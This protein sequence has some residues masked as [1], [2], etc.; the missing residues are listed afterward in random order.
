MALQV[1]SLH[2]RI[3]L[4]VL[5]PLLGASIPAGY[6]LWHAQ[7]D[8][9]EMRNLRALADLVWRLGDLEAR[10]DAEAEKW[11]FFKPSYEATNA[12]RQAERLNQEQQRRE[13]DKAIAAYNA[14]RAAIESASLSAP[15]QAALD[16]IA[17][18]ITHLPELRKM[19]Y[20]QVDETLSVPIMDG[21]RGFR[22]DIDQVLPLLVDA[23][24]NSAITRKLIV[25]PKL[26]LVRKTAMDA[27]GMIFY[28]HQL[29][30]SKS[31][32]TF[33]PSEALQM[34]QGADLAEL[35]WADV[36]A[37]SQGP[38]RNH[39]VALH[40]SPD[41]QR[42]V[43]M[44]RKHA[45]AALNHTEPPISGEAEFSPSWSF[46]YG[47]LAEEIKGVREDFTQS[48]QA[49]ERA[50]QLR[51]LWIILGIG[52]GVAV[53]LWLA[54]RLGH[55]ISKP[56]AG[57]TD[58]LLSDARAVT[59][60]AETVRTSCATVAD[61]SNRQAAALEETS[62]TLEEISSMTQSNADNAQRAQ[63]SANDTRS[64]AEQGAQQMR[65][66]TEAMEALRTSSED[67]TRIIK[68]IDEIAFQTNI[69]ALNAAV[70]AARAGEAGAGFAVVAEEVRSLAQRSAQAAR[71]TTAK[72]TAANARTN[73]GAEITVKVGESLDRILQ[74]AREVETLVDSIA[75]ASREQNSGVAQIT[76]A[77]RQI[78]KVTQTNAAAAEETA[79][80]A[81]E[82]QTRAHAFRDAVEEMQHIVFGGATAQAG[83]H[84][85]D[86]T[87]DLSQSVEATTEA[88][89]EQHEEVVGK[90]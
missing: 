44:L 23:T 22:R 34:S 71:E 89:E 2:R 8:L 59:S 11:Y 86:A 57:T 18:R 17:Q 64:A 29:R 54:N 62:A 81:A 67:V 90:Q 32:R 46:L 16:S 19:V 76:T 79:A 82:L 83:A 24:S 26:M 69:L 38:M 80:S 75:A 28:Y 13:T 66:L 61:G 33:V 73:A 36:I 55:S 39:L 60:E 3:L 77:I 84:G 65:H 85:E 1:L 68:T 35:L 12:Q 45:D 37:M 41:W 70:E 5:L 27:G 49:L 21:Y 52:A 51:R 63:Q 43:D 58:R 6:L 56:V 10:L 9:A 42:V 87:L 88:A 20:A 47:T 30:A 15:L 31:T 50:A 53:V 25:L 4:L 40:E 72:I 14:Q 7:R 78:D 74:R 48:C